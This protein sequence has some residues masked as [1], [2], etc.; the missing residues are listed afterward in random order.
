MSEP[1]VVVAVHRSGDHTFSKQTLPSIELAAGLGV[2]GDAH[3]GARVKHRSRVKRDPDQ[4]NLRQVHLVAAELLDEVNGAGFDVAPGAVGENITTR[5]LD[6][7]N[8]P[9]GTTLKIGAALLALTGLRRPCG[10]V[11]GFQEGLQGAILRRND[12]QPE[13][14]IGAM[15]VVLLGGTVSAGDPIAIGAPAGEPMPMERI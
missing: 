7:L 15:S 14:M 3:M 11:E 12:G 6:L 13:R 10:Q 9:V 8:L 5:G 4:P 2:T 1:P